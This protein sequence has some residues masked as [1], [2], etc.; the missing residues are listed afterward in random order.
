M[1]KVAIIGVALGCG[2]PNHGCADGPLALKQSGILDCL[3][4]GECRP[5][6]F[7]ILQEHGQ[8][9]RGALD[10]V[11]AV[12][13]ELEKAVFD[14][15]QQGCFPL[16]VG[17]DHSCA[18][19]TWNAIYASLG[20][21]CSLGLLWVDAHMDSHVP[22]TS[23]SGAWHGM[24]LACLLGYGHPSL[25]RIMEGAP[26]LKPEH[27][28]LYGVRSYEPEEA[29]LLARLGVKV[30]FMEEVRTRGFA[31]TWQ[32][33][34][35]HVRRGT[36][37]YG[38]S[39]DLDVIDPVEAPGVGSPAPGG[40]SGGTLVSALSELCGAQGAQGLLAVEISEYDPHLDRDQMTLHLTRRLISAVV[41]GR[42]LDE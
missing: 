30:V 12:N 11:V 35:E 18:V 21:S 19:G 39:L 41:D 10:C 42:D 17:G 29:A 26:P 36:V 7:E 34:L 2:A 16:V 8:P 9:G 24:P 22:E 3:S 27:V 25:T 13:V 28:C 1:R 23:P 20:G 15:V 32:E 31:T 5:T 4:D 37:G 6:D 38:I 33:A 14:K 40:L